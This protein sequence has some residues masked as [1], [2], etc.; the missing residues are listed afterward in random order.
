MK[1]MV[2]RMLV[3]RT[4]TTERTRRKERVRRTD[5]FR[6]MYAYQENDR[7]GEMDKRRIQLQVTDRETRE[8][9]FE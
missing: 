5:R 4:V 3:C 9:D 6:N 2:E 8:I 1:L 7:E